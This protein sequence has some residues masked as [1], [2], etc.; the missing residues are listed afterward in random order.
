MSVL[1]VLEKRRQWVQQP[2]STIRASPA[3]F[4]WFGGATLDL[5]VRRAAHNARHISGPSAHQVRHVSSPIR[6]Q[7][8]L[9]LTHVDAIPSPIVYI[10]DYRTLWVDQ[11][12]M[13]RPK[14]ACTIGTSCRFPAAP[15]HP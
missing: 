12:R 11:D 3:G 2:E 13:M 4:P 8:E 9:V 14:H 7:T 15:M 5:F 6:S 10:S 1:Q